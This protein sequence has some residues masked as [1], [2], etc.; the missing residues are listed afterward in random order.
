MSSVNNSVINQTLLNVVWVFYC[1]LLPHLLFC[2]LIRR[3]GYPTA[4]G[5]LRKLVHV[6]KF[7]QTKFPVIVI[8]SN[9]RWFHD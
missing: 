1:A 6:I 8:K 2:A 9:V 4:A 3:A 7:G 5:C